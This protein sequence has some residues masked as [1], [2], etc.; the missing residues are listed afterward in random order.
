MSSSLIQTPRSDRL[1]IGIFGRRNAGKSSLINSITGQGVSIV[2]ALP[3]TTTDPVYKSME[4]PGLGPCVFIDTAGY[5]DEGDI[6]SARVESTRTVLQ[7]TDIALLV[8]DGIDMQCDKV[9]LDILRGQNIPVIPVHSHTDALNAGE[10]HRSSEAIRKVFGQVPLSAEDIRTGH[11]RGLFDT[12][13]SMLPPDWE[14]KSITGGLCGT[15]DLVLLVMPQDLQAPKGRLILPQVQVIRE[16]LDKGCAIMSCTAENMESALDSLSRNPRLIITDSQVF[17]RVW[18]LKPADSLLTSFSV[19]MAGYK[20]DMQAFLNGAKA[21]ASLGPHSHVLIAEACT[22]APINED[23]GR[24]KLPGIL[25]SRF[26]QSLSVDIVSGKSFPEHLERYDL[27]IH[28]GGC[29]FNRRF[30]L[31]RIAKA[32]EKGIPIC[33]YGVALAAL[34]G[35]LDKIVHV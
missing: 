33:N 10:R 24:V 3:G 32:T 35:I 6:G 23:I 11:C 34:N 21:L 1:H 2:S 15:G 13:L 27:I 18:P 29:M 31:S 9:W 22:H 20:G 16:L 8:T 5:D 26:G 28:C 4:I 19:L 25:R 7:S 12:I 14:A 17:A 30:M